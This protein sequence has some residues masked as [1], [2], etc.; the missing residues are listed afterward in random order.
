MIMPGEATWLGMRAEAITLRIARYR[1]RRRM[2]MFE[3]SVLQALAELGLNS[4]DLDPHARALV[5]EVCARGH[6][7]GDASPYALALEFF[8][9]LTLEYPRLLGQAGLH[10][11]L[12]AGAIRTIRTWRL[13]DRLDVGLA[14]AGIERIKLGLLAR[15]DELDIGT[16]AE[17]LDLEERIREL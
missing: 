8:L 7:Q 2:G 13:V 14:E 4:R 16:D 12:M 15:L 1:E 5:R 17:R 9:R 10:R 3:R 6:A 11:G